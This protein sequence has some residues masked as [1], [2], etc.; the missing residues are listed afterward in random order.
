[1]LAADRDRLTVKVRQQDEAIL[2]LREKLAASSERN[3]AN[4][5]ALKARDCEDTVTDGKL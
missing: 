5:R 1:M 2:A 3:T 4:D